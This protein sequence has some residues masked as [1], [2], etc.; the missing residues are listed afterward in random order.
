M[1]YNKCPFLWGIPIRRASLIETE[2]SLSPAAA[3]QSR[4]DVPEQGD[5]L[6]TDLGLYDEEFVIRVKDSGF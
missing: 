2:K 5:G 1:R 3:L 4:D 6:V